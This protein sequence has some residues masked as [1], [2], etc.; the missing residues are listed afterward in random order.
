MLVLCP[1]NLLHRL[2]LH[3]LNVNKDALIRRNPVAYIHSHSLLQ[4][5]LHATK[6]AAG[7]LRPLNL[8]FL[9]GIRAADEEYYIAG[10]KSIVELAAHF[11]S[12]PMIDDSASKS[13]FLEQAQHSRL[14]HIH[15]HCIWDS[16][17][18]LDHHLEFP[19]VSSAPNSEQCPDHA[20]HI[21]T[22]CEVFSLRLQQ[23]VHVNLIARSGGLTDVKAGDEVIGLV[24]ALLYSG[25]SS[26]VSTIW[27]IQDHIGARFSKEFFPHSPSKL[28]SRSSVES[29][30]WKKS[31]KP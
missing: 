24:P 19:E 22:T 26:T 12:I 30:C 14:L 21:L 23:G 29:F 28:K 9:S 7:S 5:N 15:T 20:S 4:T 31:A 10:H 6:S 13:S 2:P 8:Q 17:N 25:A 27:P 18:P 16:T 11:Q 3:A 1:T